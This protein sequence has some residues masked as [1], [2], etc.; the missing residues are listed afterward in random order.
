VLG[1]P[2]RFGIGYGLVNETVSHINRGRTDGNVCFWGGWGGSSVVID[3]DRRMVFAYVMNKMV[4]GF[5]G[6]QTGKALA[7]AVYDIVE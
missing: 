6:N 5:L 3:V 2:L 7:A 4:A 1:V